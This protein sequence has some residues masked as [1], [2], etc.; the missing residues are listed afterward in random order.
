MTRLWR[1]ECSKMN[2]KDS[3]ELIALREYETRF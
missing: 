3:E 2:Y 1:E